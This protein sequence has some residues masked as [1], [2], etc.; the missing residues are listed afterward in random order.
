MF[1]ISTVGEPGVHGAGRT[2]THAMG[3][4]TPNAAAVA[5]IT[6]GF[7]GE[8]HIPNEG[9]LTIGILSMIVAAGVPV[10]TWFAGRTISDA[11]AAPKLH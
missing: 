10:R 8:L 5:E 7:V 9:T 1:P 3:V 6:S 4:S 2:G 11:G